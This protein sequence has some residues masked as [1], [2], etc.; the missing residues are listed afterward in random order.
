MILVDAGE[1]SE[2]A[3][4]A[5]LMF[6]AQLS[7]RGYQVGID[8]R[9]IPASLDRH[10]KYEM[11]PFLVDALGSSVSTFLIIGAEAVSTETLI[12]LQSF[13]FNADIPVAAIGRFG[14]HQALI[15]AGSKIAYVLGREPQIVDLCQLQKKPLLGSAIFPLTGRDI[16]LRRPAKTPLQLFLFVPP[17]LLA[18][19]FSVRLLGALD[20]L[21]GFRLNIVADAHSRDKIRESRLSHL[22]VFGPAEFA[23]STFATMADI[24]VFFGD[25][26]PG[27]RMAGFAADMFQSSKIVID[28]T[29]SAAFEACGAPVLRGPEDLAALA[30]YLSQTVITNQEDIGGF[31]S[32]SPWLA[33]HRI[34]QLE[35]ALGL[36]PPPEPEMPE[37][38]GAGRTV[39]LPT[40]GVGLGHAQRCLLIAAAMQKPENCAFAAFPSCVSMI[41]DQGFAC[42]ALVQKSPHH[43]E[44]Y[45]NDLVNY[46]RLQ[47]SLQ[48]G[49]RLV[50]DG[51]Y[52][53]ESIYRLIFEKQLSAIWVRRGLWQA[54]QA[55]AVT[56][57]REKAFRKV[58]V[59][60]EAF[61]ELN[62]EHGYGRHIHHVGPIVQ[63]RAASP[64]GAQGLRD[65]LGAHF[66]HPVGELVVTMLGSGVAADRTAQMQ[67]LC[68]IAERRTTCL[69]L[70]VVWPGAV[71]PASMFGWNHTRVVHSR[72]AL[73][74][75][76]AADLVVSAV[77]YNS[78]HEILYH[79]IP[80]ILVPQMAP[81]MDDQERRA[82]AASERGLAEMILAPELLL[83]ER[84]VR[85]FLEGGK[86]ASIRA[87][88]AVTPL[89]PRGNQAAAALVDEGH[90]A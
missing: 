2:R 30:N 26:V 19:P 76:K 52:V 24:V 73:A 49:D 50:F 40:N 44:V 1:R 7:A 15:S 33:G 17:E 60:D 77:G 22:S 12:T 78:F 71:V 43:P 32:K 16:N 69:H 18:D 79:Q 42:Q 31:I 81:F 62:S 51:G 63:E 29:H 61:E 10:Q 4:D 90:D 56:L 88:L 35:K 84:G 82:R 70:I 68:N 59:P 25:G 85:A 67:T 58:I 87:R 21:R 72:N 83:L 57:E 74:L 65:R 36:A 8:D 55:N 3:F 80:A 75:C 27:E 89:P 34:Q 48:A 5:K 46:L 38:S 45:A 53:F 86:A 66:G 11:A 47:R 39:F 41:E 9:T 28:C 23:P 20:N 37:P 64:V 13:G 14:D 54:G 6:A